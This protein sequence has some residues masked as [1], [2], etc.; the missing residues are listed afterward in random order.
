MI[1]RE[2]P[3]AAAFLVCGCVA[4]AAAPQVDD[5]DL[6]AYI[7]RPVA[8]TK[9]AGYLQR[10]GAVLIVGYND[11]NE[12]F[13]SLNAIFRKSHPE[14]TF[15]MQLKGTA[16]GAPALTLGVSAFAPM[17]AE[18][19]AIEL[20]SYKSFLGARPVPFRVAHCS[21]NSNALS[22]PVGIFVNKVN[23]IQNLTVEQVARIFTT[24]SS[25]G[26]VTHWGQLGLK[27]EWAARRIR[28]CGIAEEAAAG[29]AAFMLK[30][31]GGWPFAPAYDPFLQSSQVIQRLQEDPG[32]IGFAS[33]N[34]ASPETKLIAIA[35][36]EGGY[37]SS[38]TASDVVSG[39]Y[40]YNRYLFIYVRRI[41][42]EPI[43]P[44]VKEYLRLVLSR[45]GQRAIAAAPPHY[46]PL[47]GREIVEELAKLEQ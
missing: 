9:H 47:N 15:K 34:L 40:P 11:M 22:A 3:A 35:E 45:E 16:T 12:V 13:A 36:S 29:L 5:R 20:E 44:F 10:D 37:Y 6:P 28:P 41:P 33:G 25:G 39:K 30:K 1:Y 19:S 8:Q 17:G 38:M 27:G 31:M 21:L 23:P 43:D 14:F 4:L 26:D 32:A 2:A 18:F 7:P 46:L 42:G 24:G